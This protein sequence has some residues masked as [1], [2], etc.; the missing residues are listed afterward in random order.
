[1]L[2]FAWLQSPAMWVA[3]SKQAGLQTEINSYG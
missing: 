2:E 1:M 3:G